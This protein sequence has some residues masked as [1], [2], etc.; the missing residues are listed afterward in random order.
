MPE[1][2]TVAIQNDPT[3]G[4]RALLLLQDKGVIKLK[5]DVGL[6]AER[7]RHRDNPKKLKFVEIDAAQ[8]PR[9]LA[10]VDAASINTNY[11]VEAGP[12]PKA[13]RSCQRRR[14]GPLCQRHRGAHRRQGQA[15]GED[16]RRSLPR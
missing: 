10:D 2:A 15:L 14:Q 3:N 12:D 9:S 7:R 5:P 8:L 4:G 1:G 16:P 11:A 6:K 13:T